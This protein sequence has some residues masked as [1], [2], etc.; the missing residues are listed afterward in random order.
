MSNKFNT[1]AILLIILFI[2]SFVTTLFPNAYLWLLAPGMTD[3]SAITAFTT[4]TKS[5]AFIYSV[6][7]FSVNIGC[8]TWLYIEAKKESSYAFVW[9]ALGLFSGLISV[10]L[11][12]LKGIH[13]KLSIEKT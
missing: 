5:L 4:Q 9:L 11:W 3:Q 13:E 10:I 12:Y 8:A 7:S 2:A 6:L 1:L